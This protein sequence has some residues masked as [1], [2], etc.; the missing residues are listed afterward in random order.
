VPSPRV[1]SRVALSVAGLLVVAACGGAPQT[2]PDDEPAVTT[3]VPGQGETTASTAAPATTRAASAPTAPVGTVAG[4]STTTAPAAGAPALQIRKGTNGRKVVALTFDAGS[5]VGFTG[6]I[7]DIL[8]AEQIKVSFGMTGKWAEQ[9]PDMFRRIVAEGHHLV[10]HT[11]SHKSWTGFS[12]STAL[13]NREARIAELD[14]AEQVFKNLAGANVTSKPWFRPPY[15]DVDNETDKL[16]GQMG[17]KYD[18]LWTVDS[19]GWMGKT[20]AQIVE[21]CR[22]GFVPGGILLFHVGEQSQDGNA[23]TQIIKEVRAAGLQPGS[24]LDVV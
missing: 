19:L 1:L 4:A 20:A 7:L 5:D 24:L 11:Y 3:T 23:L 15:G 2:A 13:L 18:A 9:N 12:S 8:K 10:N 16:L 14:K 17:Y 6:Q 22:K 21:I